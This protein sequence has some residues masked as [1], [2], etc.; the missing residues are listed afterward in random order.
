MIIR[1]YTAWQFTFSLVIIIVC[2]GMP[3]GMLGSIRIKANIQSLQLKI[4]TLH[5]FYLKVNHIFQ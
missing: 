1:S 2:K 5:I 3:E 4:V